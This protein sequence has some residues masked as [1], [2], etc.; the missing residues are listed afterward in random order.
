MPLNMFN[1]NVVVAASVFNP[2]IVNQFWLIKNKIITEETDTQGS[3]FVDGFSQLKT[4]EFLL[5]VLPQRLQFALAD[6]FSQKQDIVTEKVGTVVKALPHTPYTACGLNF[7]WHLQPEE[8]DISTLSRR[9]FYRENNAIFEVFDAH[10]PRF[11]AYMSCDLLGGRY[12]LDIKPIKAEL[13][14]GE[15][16]ELL[17]FSFNCH[18]DLSDAGDPAGRIEE[19]LHRWDEA[20]QHSEKLANSALPFDHP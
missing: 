5:T 14:E 12:K 17:Q 8:T 16:L 10:S 15:E 19:F 13:P 3:I 4:D 9:M 7:T 2:S 1:A 6:P 18:L 11:G 20:Y